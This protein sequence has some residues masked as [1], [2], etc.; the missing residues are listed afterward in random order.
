[1]FK[2]IDK[3]NLEIERF[4]SNSNEEIEQFRIAYLGKKGKVTLLFSV[5]KQVSNEQ[6]RNLVNSLIF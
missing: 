4:Q 1:M 3:I 5:F 2:D 6:K